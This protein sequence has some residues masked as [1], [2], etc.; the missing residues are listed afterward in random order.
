MHQGSPAQG[1]NRCGPSVPTTRR[2]ST[3]PPG[4][5]LCPSWRR[6]TRGLPGGSGARRRCLGARVRASPPVS[7]PFAFAS[8]AFLGVRPSAVV[9]YYVIAF[10]GGLLLPPRPRARLHLG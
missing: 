7:R 6:R 1:R 4:A 2:A 9:D 10:A 5:W 3:V 8:E